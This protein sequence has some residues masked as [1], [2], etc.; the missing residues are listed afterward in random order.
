MDRLM[1]GYFRFTIYI[2]TQSSPL[3]ESHKQW[4]NLHISS[5][6]QIFFFTHFCNPG[7]LFYW[8][9]GRKTYFTVPHV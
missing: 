7:I 1:G 9:L 8:M 6:L 2:V 5:L 3:K 4:H